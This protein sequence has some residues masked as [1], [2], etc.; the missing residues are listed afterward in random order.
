MDQT[1][2][3]SQDMEKYFDLVPL[4]SIPDSD[5]FIESESDMKKTRKRRGKKIMKELTINL[6]EL[7]YAV[8]EAMNRLR[9]KY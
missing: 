1:I 3:S 8:E 6:P 7:P 5:L 9:I 2:H 4:T